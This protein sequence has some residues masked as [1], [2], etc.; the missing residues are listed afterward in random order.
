[1]PKRVYKSHNPGETE[2]IGSTLAKTLSKGDRVGLVGELGSGKTCFVRGLARGLGSEGYIKSPSFTMIN[3]YEGGRLPLYHIDLYRIG[4]QEEFE[5][6]GLEE[7]IYG[8][9]VS[10]IEWADN[11]PGLLDRCNLVVKFSYMGETEREIEVSVAD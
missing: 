10:V 8:G 2:E 4:R 7:Y 11:V 6:T 5:E 1:M 9:G 3:I